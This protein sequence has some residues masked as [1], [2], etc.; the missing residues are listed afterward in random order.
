MPRLRATRSSATGAAEAAVAAPSVPWTP[1]ELS[2][3]IWLDAAD[4]ATI[5]LNGSSVSQWND[6]SGNGR[7]A[8]QATASQQPTYLSA[9]VNS[10]N[11]IS[12]DGS[13]DRLFRVGSFTVSS[14]S[15]FVISTPTAASSAYLFLFS[16]NKQNALISKYASPGN[17]EVYVETGRTVLSGTATG[18]NISY[19]E[20]SGTTATGRFNATLGGTASLTDNTT[21]V[22]SYYI[23]SSD[24]GDY[25]NATICE[26]LLFPSVLST[27]DRQKCE[28]YLAHK[29]GLTASLPSDH[30]YKAAP[31]YLP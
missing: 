4:A 29:W 11:A 25:S 15:C 20:F 10:K 30:P 24:A 23:G 6:K 19:W 16:R 12:F 13:N 22:N 14:Y 7:H 5:T 9:A 26:I 27:L 2:T 3:A 28:G 17:Y 8:T 18:Q 31:P 21:T 1:A